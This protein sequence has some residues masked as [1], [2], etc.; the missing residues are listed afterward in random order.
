[1]GLRDVDHGQ[2]PY[3][4]TRVAEEEWRDLKSVRLAA[5]AES[6]EAFASDFSTEARLSEV[7]WRG[8]A[9]KGATFLAR[10]EHTPIGMAAGAP[11]NAPED[12]G[13]VA[14]WVHP[15]HRGHGVAGAMVQAVER[16]ARAERAATLTLWVTRVNRPAIRLYRRLGFVP[17]GR[18][19]PLPSDPRLIEDQLVLD[20][21]GS[22]SLVS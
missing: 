1:M 8:W 22:S 2:D 7:D 12:R 3:V 15:D 11:G 6:P 18:S 14:V 9:R 16:W 13:L 20:L 19:Q 17:T 10:D 5:L 21:R 4:V